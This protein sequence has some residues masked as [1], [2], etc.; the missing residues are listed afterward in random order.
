MQQLKEWFHIYVDIR[1]TSE[2]SPERYLATTERTPTVLTS[3]AQ[4]SG[5][6][7]FKLLA[8]P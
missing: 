8:P 2:T 6:Q 1:I 7:Y 4:Q 5:N 3:Q